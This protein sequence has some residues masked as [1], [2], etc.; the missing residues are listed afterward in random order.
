MKNILSALCFILSITFLSAQDITVRGQLVEKGSNV[1]VEFA[2]ISIN[3]TATNTILDGASSD[4]D[5]KFALKVPHKNIAIEVSFIGMATQTI[6]DFQLA[7]KTIDLGTIV[8]DADGE[9]LDEVVVMGEKS[10]TVFKLDKKVFNVGA[11]LSNTGASA[12][13]VLNNV[14]SVTVDIEGQVSLRGASGVQM[15]INGKPSVLASSEGNALGTITADMIERIEVIT[16][17]SAKYDAEGTA[18]ILNIVLKKEEKRG[19]NGSVTLNT[20][21]PNNHSIGLSLNRRT[22]KFNLFSQFGYGYRTFPSTSNSVSRNK[23]IQSELSTVGE[24]DKNEQFYNVI[25]GTD[26]HINKNNV[27]TLSG[28]FAYEKEKEDGTSS[29]KLL[30]QNDDAQAWT[31]TEATTA[32]NPKWEY[33]LQY[34]RDFESHKDRNLLFSAQG[35]SFG[36]SKTSLF[37][38][39]SAQ[40][41]TNKQ[42]AK[43]DFSEYEYTFKL[44]YTHPFSDIYTI[45][46][47]A[48]YVLDDVSNDYA[49][50][51]LVSGSWVSNDKLTNVFD[52][53][54]KVLA[55]YATFAVE[56]DKWG[57]KG[58]L[59]VE[60]TDLATKLKNTS[61]TNNQ[62]YT[63]YFPSTHVSY[64]VT[65]SFSLQ[66]GYSKR[67]YRPRLW[68]LN[69]FFSY[70]D[71][72]NLFTGNPMLSPEY[73][74]SYELTSIHYIGGL[75]LNAGIYHRRTT[76]VIE[77]VTSYEGNISTTRP[78]NIGQNNMTGLELNAKISPA[79]WLTLSTDMNFNSYV[80]TG[81]YEGRSFDFNGSRWSSRLMSKWK[82]PADIDLEVS[83]NYRSP[84][85]TVQGKT[86]QDSYM[87]LGMRKKILKGRAIISLSVRDVLASRARRSIADQTDFYRE[88]EYRRGRYVTLGFSYGF[89]KGEAMEF[90][91]QKRF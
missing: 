39:N 14:P 83:G 36:K 21:F 22:E 72:Y 85:T 57:V 66:G 71:D 41:L 47:G 65:E 74:D 46:T 76:D 73:T 84:Y 43:T 63:D 31:R 17:P 3:D 81:S 38:I 1:P 64:K 19:I 49:I 6:T 61:T 4:V 15:L 23:S 79:R 37:D 27:L 8:M 53:S 60:N 90:S 20:G 45:E 42:Q 86:L 88:S 55:S 54:Q 32:T 33:E 87:D 44:D 10:Q 56:L 5:G 12:L 30:R 78:E 34:K 13:E 11:D 2:T 75:S 25:L 69:P 29:Y 52:Y 26:Y 70:R 58:G 91:G 24:N 50:S 82:L 89:G 62:N 51:D 35:S 48:Q 67:I 9:M 16:N 59:R 40:N 28:N 18:G 80:R 77:R 7:N 68:D